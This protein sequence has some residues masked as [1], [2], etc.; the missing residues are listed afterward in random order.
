MGKKSY[1]EFLSKRNMKIELKNLKKA[2]GMIGI[3]VND[4]QTE[5]VVEFC[6]LLD[7]KGQDVTLG[8]VERVGD[9]VARKQNLN[10]ALV[11]GLQL[12]K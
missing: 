2:L 10:K 9:E 1:N 5:M 6:K 3:Q 8:D 4:Q 7:E 12:N 11:Q